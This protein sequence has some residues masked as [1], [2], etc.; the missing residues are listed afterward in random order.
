MAS[1]RRRALVDFVENVSGKSTRPAPA[2]PRRRGG[3]RS[4]KPQQRGRLNWRAGMGPPAASLK[5]GREGAPGGSRPARPRPQPPAAPPAGPPQWRAEEAE[6]PE[7]AA[8]RI[9]KRR[10]D[11]T[12]AAARASSAAGPTAPPPEPGSFDEFCDPKLRCQ[13]RDHQIEAAR[14]L[15]RR[16]HPAAGPAAAAGPSEGGA[17]L[18]DDMGL[19]KTLTSIALVH[20]TI[21]RHRRL[22]DRAPARAESFYGPQRKE[23]FRGPGPGGDPSGGDRSAPR[24][25]VVAPTTLVANWRREFRKWV[26]LGGAA[27]VRVVSLEGRDRD[28]GGR[29]H[30]WSLSPSGGVLLLSYEAFVK[31]RLAVCGARNLCI[32]VADEAHR[33]K[34]FAGTHASAAADA[35][36][37]ARRLAV[38]GTPVQNSLM[39]LFA[40][41]R[42]VA[43]REAARLAGGGAA[44][45][46]DGDADAAAQRFR[47][48]FCGDGGARGGAELARVCERIVVRRTLRE[49]LA[50]DKVMLPPRREV[51]VLCRMSER[52]RSVMRRLIERHRGLAP[53]GAD[54]LRLVGLMRRL[55]ASPDMVPAGELAGGGEGRCAED[56][57]EW[58]ERE[59]KGEEGKGEGGC[60]SGKIAVL[61]Q[62]LRAIR[63]AGARERVVI[64]CS[65]L[66]SVRLAG[67]ACEEEG[68]DWLRLDGSTPAAQRQATVDAFQRGGRDGGRAPFAFVTTA[69]AGGVGL[70]LTAARYLV[71]FEG[72][73]NPA[74][75]AQAMARVWR[76]GQTR[77]V[78]IYRL[79]AEGGVDERILEVQARKLRIAAAVGMAGSGGEAAPGEEGAGEEEGAE[80]AIDLGE[81]MAPPDREAWGGGRTVPPEEVG[82]MGDPVLAAAQARLAAGDWIRGAVLMK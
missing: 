22:L 41:L 3:G 59:G 63:S 51:A 49:V 26:Q 28:A 32:M 78:T 74:V 46:P 40:L 64:V 77:P 38:T 12:A 81:L 24:A 14:F 79:V 6:E 19:G 5:R 20:A 18:A 65:F 15:W 52:Q 23:F 11:A 9:A 30:G 82:G 58:E 2:E 66:E 42:L 10:R 31:H 27:E 39:E 21:L 43:P 55:C 17:I 13:M 29:V 71:L 25:V 61:R 4:L 80:E 68:L 57:G 75:D 36:P 62:L 67:G 72:D 45:A 7:K 8:L 76:M 34:N 35:F 37:S 47:R 1:S 44:G 33:L 56:E 48:R 53:G 60:G 73:W 16:L 70:T 69:R 50:R 54:A